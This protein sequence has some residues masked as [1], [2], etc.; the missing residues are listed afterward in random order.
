MKALIQRVSSASVEVDGEVVG[1]IQR[2]LLVLL[3]VE[4]HDS[5]D[6]AEKLV[7]KLLNYRVFADENDKMNLCV[8]DIDGGLLV[9]SQ[10]TLAASTTKGLRPSFSSAAEPALAK[11]YYEYCIENIKKQL[12]KVETGI[13]AADMQVK[14]VN[15]GPV[16]FM[17]EA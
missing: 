17:L 13:F 6:T 7:H 2:G 3:A 16:T 9:V 8:K 15:D 14:L 1:S 10:F 11:E 12:D 4:K 5:T